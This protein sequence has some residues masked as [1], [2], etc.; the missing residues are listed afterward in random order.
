M[1]L[2]ASNCEVVAGACGEEVSL[3]QRIIAPS[4]QSAVGSQCQTVPPPSCKE[5][6]ISQVGG[7]DGLTIIVII[8]WICDKS[9]CAPRHDGTAAIAFDVREWAQTHQRYDQ[10]QDPTIFGHSEEVLAASRLKHSITSSRH[11][12]A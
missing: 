7:H 5:H 11:C 1:L 8:G 2:A 9:P 10:D 6:G 4:A 3:A 12:D